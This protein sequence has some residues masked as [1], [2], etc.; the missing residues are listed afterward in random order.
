MQR[1]VC[2]RLSEQC[3]DFTIAC[4]V[5]TNDKMK[6]LSQH[7]KTDFWAQ[8]EKEVSKTI[9]KSKQAIFLDR[10]KRNHAELK[11]EL[12]LERIDSFAKEVLKLFEEEE[13]E[14][15]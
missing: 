7:L 10:F 15:N 3:E 5:E 1:P 14:V 6:S 11:G 4:T 13:E 8:L 12:N 2:N 9:P